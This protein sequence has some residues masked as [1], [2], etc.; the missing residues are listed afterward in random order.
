M[1]DTCHPEIL[2][3][4]HKDGAIGVNIDSIYFIVPEEKK[5]KTHSAVY[6]EGLDYPLIVEGVSS[7]IIQKWSEQL[8][9]RDAIAAGYFDADDSDDE[10]SDDA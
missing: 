3:C 9:Y 2:I 5:F 1:A 4:R 10:K 6:V 8:F 7:D